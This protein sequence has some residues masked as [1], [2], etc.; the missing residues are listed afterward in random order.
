MRARPHLFACVRC[1]RRCIIEDMTRLLLSCTLMAL[2]AAGIAHA[3]W[4]DPRDTKP[5]DVLDLMNDSELL[6]D[7]PAVC[8][9]GQHFVRPA[10]QYLDP[11]PLV[12]RKHG[13]GPGWCRDTGMRR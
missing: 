4:L 3:E 11:F 13:K 2:V 7:A 5:V 12:A 9:L 1:H 8:W 6:N 10:S